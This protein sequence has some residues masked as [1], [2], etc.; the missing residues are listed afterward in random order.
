MP[1]FGKRCI[2]THI[3][4]NHCVHEGDEH[5]LPFDGIIDYKKTARQ[6]AE[7]GY[8]GTLTLELALPEAPG[9]RYADITAREYAEKAFSAA[10]R[11][12]KLCEEAEK[13]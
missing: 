12:R 9:D 13:E 7:A 11:I 10:D 8:H 5:L 6:I 3:H 4:D 1:L 2:Y